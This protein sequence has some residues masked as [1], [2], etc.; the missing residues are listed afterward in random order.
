MG[1]VYSTRFL[2]GGPS[3][4]QISAQCP[5]GKRW[6]VKQIDIYN[7]AGAG[8]NA[9]LQIAGITIAASVPLASGAILHWSGMQVLYHGE[10]VIFIVGGAGPVCCVSGYQFDDP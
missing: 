3:S 9:L 6:V 1:A 4:G 5:T 8:V 10:S 2:S 7:G